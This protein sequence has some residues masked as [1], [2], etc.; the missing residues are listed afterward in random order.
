M[1]LEVSVPMVSV[2][3][4]SAVI[5]A[6]PET[7]ARL[8]MAATATMATSAASADR[9]LST[10][11]AAL[12]TTTLA[13]A[14]AVTLEA[15]EAARSVLVVVSAEAAS[16]EAVALVA[17]VAEASPAAVAV[18]ISVDADNNIPQKLYHSYL[19][20]EKQQNNEKDY[21]NGCSGNDDIACS[22]SGNL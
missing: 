11:T 7:T 18:P 8:T 19:Y 2:A 15:Q 22:R 13:E 12:A 5:G 1:A 4:I 14:T 16:V 20:I 6:V 3:A 21:H 9:Q 17:P 10:A